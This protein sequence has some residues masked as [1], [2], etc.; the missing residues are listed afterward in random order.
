MRRRLGG[1]I[2]ARGVFGLDTQS[3]VSGGM[4]VPSAIVLP[5]KADLA[6]LGRQCPEALPAAV[7]VGDPCYDG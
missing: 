1:A 6:V 2:A 5:H 4:V 3:L 7:V